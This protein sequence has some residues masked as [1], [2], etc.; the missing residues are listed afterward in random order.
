[1]GFFV[2][3]NFDEQKPALEHIADLL[4]AT[5]SDIVWSQGQLKIRPYGDEPVSGNGA[6]YAPN[7]T[8]LYDLTD[9]DFLVDGDEDPVQVERKPASDAYNSCPIEFTNRA[10]DYNA[11]VVEEPDPVDVEIFGTRRAPKK[12]LR[13]ITRAAHAQQLSRIL[14]QRNVYTKNRYQFYLGWRYVLLE[15]MDLVTLTDAGLGLD[16]RPVRILEIE[17]DGEGRLRVEAEEWPFGIAMRRCSMC[18][19]AMAPHQTSMPTRATPTPGHLRAAVDTD[20]RR[21][22]IVARY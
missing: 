7:V 3:P 8:P 15:P 9:D 18:R 1:M 5:N 10:Q 17:E 22:G 2:S 12:T 13:M 11:S 4:T 16:K 6:S 19:T 20:R 14:A 21:A